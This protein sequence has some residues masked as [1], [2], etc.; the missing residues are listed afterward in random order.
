VAMPAR[1]DRRGGEQTIA[2]DGGG[3]PAATDRT[4]G[5]LTR[6]T[7]ARMASQAGL[8]DGGVGPETCC[9]GSLPVVTYLQLSASGLVAAALSL[10]MRDGNVCLWW[11]ASYL[12][13]KHPAPRA[14]RTVRA[15]RTRIL[16]LPAE[17]KPTWRLQA[18][19]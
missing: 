5:A 12:S 11:R 14:P 7:G 13:L 16:R 10:S 18:A 3:R 2:T 9:S 15:A 17:N 6:G 19:A 1:H 4:S 8:G